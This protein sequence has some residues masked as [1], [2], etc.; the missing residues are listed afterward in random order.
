MRIAKRTDYA[1]RVLL[2]LAV[3]PGERFSTQQIAEAHGLSLNHLHKV[4][5]DLGE[6]KLVMLHRG[7]KGGVEL[8]KDP[9]DISVGKVVRAFEDEDMLV[10]CFIEE[11]NTCVISSACKLKKSL[12]GA[13]EAFFKHLDPTT[14]MDLVR[15]RAANALRGLLDVED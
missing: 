11:S 2:Y 13:Q 3:R 8:A 10:E 6:L 5:R 1:L 15:G 14:I 7:A 9:A 4:V 12:R